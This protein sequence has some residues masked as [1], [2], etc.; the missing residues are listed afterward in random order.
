[1]KLSVFTR[2]VRRIHMYLALFLT[3]WILMYTLSSL[4]FN[5][6]ATIRNWYGGDL[7]QYET[8]DEMAY[9]DAFSADTTPAEAAKQILLD[10]DMDGSHFVRGNLNGENFTIMRPETYSMKRVTYYPQEGRIS[11]EKQVANLPSMLTRMHIRSGYVQKY[12]STKLWALGVEIT[13]LAMIF[14]I[15][16]GA[17]LWW[18]IKPARMWGGICMLGG[19][20]LFA[21]L[22]FSI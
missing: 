21:V 4:V 15:A 20:G 17:W 5:H 3:P 7:N 19:L 1:M 12:A 22:L 2:Y 9:P 11:V 16:S 14:W 8:V 6:F 13:A 18:T 10:L